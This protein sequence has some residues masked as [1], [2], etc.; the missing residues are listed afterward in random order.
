MLAQFLV[1]FLAAGA[2]AS[3]VPSGNEKS[4][5]SSNPQPKSA[6][7]HP[8]FESFT[9]AIPLSF[10]GGS[11]ADHFDIKG[12]VDNAKPIHYPSADYVYQPTAHQRKAAVDDAEPKQKP[13]PT[14]FRTPRSI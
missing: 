8:A 14:H 4:P 13:P 2:I 6:K 10:Q 5:S 3:P 7:T 9:Q 12:G 11:F 1:A